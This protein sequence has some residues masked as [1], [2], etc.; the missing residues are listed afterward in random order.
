MA[1]SKQERLERQKRHPIWRTR[2]VGGMTVAKFS[3]WSDEEPPPD[4]TKRK[5]EQE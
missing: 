4:F 3:H 2:R 1:N 5:Q